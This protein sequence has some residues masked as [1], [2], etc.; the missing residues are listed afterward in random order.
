MA[1]EIERKFLVRTDT[2]RQ[3]VSKSSSF[4]QGYILSGADR[5]VRIRIRDRA[6][7]LLTIKIGHVGLSRDEFEYEIALADG[8]EMIDKAQGNV[9]EK[10]RYNVE[11]G[12][13]LWEVDVFAGAHAGLVVA[14]VELE[15][16]CEDPPLPPWVGREVTGDGRYSNQW[17]ATSTP[18]TERRNGLSLK[19]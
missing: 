7:A 14:E 13:Y 15:N 16:D 18:Q 6:D 9:I 19:A 12:G 5:S 1:K 4:Q 2:W 17:L 3:H 11:Y 10:T 8:L